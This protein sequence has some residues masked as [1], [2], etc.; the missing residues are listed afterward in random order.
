MN[1]VDKQILE[2]GWRNVVVKL[3][4]VI[5]SADVI[6]TSAIAPGDFFNNDR[7]AGSL[8]GFRVDHVT[9][10]IGNGIE[11]VLAWNSNNPQQITPLAGRGK[12]DSTDDGGFL[13][14]TTRLGYDGSI[15]L[16]TQGF[17]PGM[18]PQNFTVFLRLVKLY[19]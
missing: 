6:E 4:G 14:D 11:V 15:N 18:P 1:L 13:P 5:D 17:L 16:Y 9:Y 2:E 10:S 3:T 8:T 19:G 12:I 7:K